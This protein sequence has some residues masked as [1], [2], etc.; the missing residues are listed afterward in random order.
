MRRALDGTAP[1]AATLVYDAMYEAGGKA[2]TIEEL[3]RMSREM[4]QYAIE[5]FWTIWGPIA[6][7]YSAVQP[8]V[9]GFNGEYKIGNGNFKAVFARLWID[10]ELKEAMGR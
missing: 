5:K 1:I 2:T 10:S 9:I 3:Y 7:E 4:N 6:P 8:W